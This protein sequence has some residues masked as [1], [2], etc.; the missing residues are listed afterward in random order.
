M[1]ETKELNCRLN[2]FLAI[3]IALTAEKDRSRLLEMI[4]TEARRITNADAGTLYL[5][6]DD[7]LYAQ[8][9]HNQSMNTFLSTIQGNI[10]LPPV[11]IQTEYVAGYVALTGKSVNIPDVYSSDKFDFTGPRKYDQMTGYRTKSMLVIPLKDHEETITGVLQLINASH[12]ESNQAIAFNIDDQQIIEALSA[13]VAISLTNTKLINDIQKILDSIIDVLTT[14]IDTQ[15]PYN[16]THT[17]KVAQLSALI[18]RE[19]NNTT[20]G[21]LASETFDDERTK[22]LVMAANLH[23]IGKV[24]T[25]LA[26]MNKATRLEQQLPLILLRFDLTMEQETSKSLEKQLALCKMQQNQAALDEE[27]CLQIKINYLKKAKALIIKANHPA[28][29]I[30][31]ALKQQLNK[32]AAITYNTADGIIAPLLTKDELTC[33]RVAKGT[34]T[35]AERQ[36]MKNHV[37]LTAKMLQKIPFTKKLALVPKIAAMHHEYLNGQGY[38]AGLK[39]NEIMLEGRILAIADIFDALTASDRPYK[40]GMPVAKAL[41]IL[42]MMV[43]DGQ[44]DR[45]IV[46]LIIEKRLW[47]QM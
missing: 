14:A 22:Q 32:I 47:E 19:I 43:K 2:N 6:K 18:A 12:P 17:Q 28:T 8:L 1:P 45:H 40:K 46:D 3:S 10:I 27:K 38:P 26:I 16:T 41:D 37:V 13:L 30:D 11:P 4:M 31:Q 44:L 34:L 42:G 39:E 5:V 24:S 35:T 20:T 21:Y 23:D 33:L 29:F 25:P 7:F 9:L 15:T 36:I